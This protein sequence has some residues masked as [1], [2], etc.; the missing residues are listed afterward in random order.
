MFLQCHCFHPAAAGVNYE[1]TVSKMPALVLS[2]QKSSP[3]HATTVVEVLVMV[4]VIVM[5]IVVVIVTV[6]VSAVTESVLSLH[7]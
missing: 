2:L 5:V 1:F 3:D 6:A 7:P 4:V